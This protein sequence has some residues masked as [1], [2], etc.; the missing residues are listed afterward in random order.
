MNTERQEIIINQHKFILRNAEDKD[1]EFVFN[2]LKENMLESF[3]RNWGFWNEKSFEKNYRKEHIRII[4]YENVNVGYVEFKF[5]KDCGYL[6]SIQLSE[7]IRGKGLGTYIMKM[8]EQETF[9]YGLNRICL[10]VFKDNRAVKL[11]KRLGYNPI[12]EDESSLIME[13]IIA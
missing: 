13:K 3:N 10:K 7:K 2:L 1:Y 5:K 11:Y 12:S 9:N 4:E 6:D 8:L